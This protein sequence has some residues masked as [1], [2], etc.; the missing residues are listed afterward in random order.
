MPVKVKGDIITGEDARA[1][2]TEDIITKSDI[3]ESE[4]T[5]IL[6]KLKSA[7]YLGSE[8]ETFYSV[9]VKLS[10]ILEEKRK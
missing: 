10:K 2:I 3:T 4:L 6:T 7:Q 8:F 9:W 1:K 5:F